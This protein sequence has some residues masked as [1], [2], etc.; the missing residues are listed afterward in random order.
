MQKIISNDQKQYKHLCILRHLRSPDD[1]EHLL[2]KLNK[3]GQNA[4]YLASKNGNLNV[5]KLLH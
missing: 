2:N 4:Y 5:L 3:H 1:P